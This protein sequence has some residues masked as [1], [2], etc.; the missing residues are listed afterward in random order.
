MRAVF[1]AKRIA[2][3]DFELFPSRAGAM[4]LNFTRRIAAYGKS[5]EK[6]R[7][8]LNALDSVGYRLLGLLFAFIGPNRA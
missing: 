3:A 6:L 8:F 1:G 7:L 2:P 5:G 4:H